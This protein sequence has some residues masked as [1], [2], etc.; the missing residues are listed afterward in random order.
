MAAG[1]TGKLKTILQV[2]CFV[3]CASQGIVEVVFFRDSQ[4]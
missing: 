2:V 4:L 1:I 3:Y